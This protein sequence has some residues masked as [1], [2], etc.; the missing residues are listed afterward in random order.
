MCLPIASCF[1]PIVDAP[2]QTCF[3]R[4]R[5]ITSSSCSQ[6]KKLSLVVRKLVG[7]LVS[8]RL[9]S[10]PEFQLYV[11][12]QDGGRY[13]QIAVRAAQRR[14]LRSSFCSVDDLGKSKHTSIVHLVSEELCTK[15]VIS[16]SSDKSVPDKFLLLGWPWDGTSIEPH[17]ICSEP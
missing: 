10:A 9:E 2:I 17:G 14:G 6:E 16:D 15:L 11:Q 5:L 3:L 12:S 7:F 13:R 8:V 4:R 1:T